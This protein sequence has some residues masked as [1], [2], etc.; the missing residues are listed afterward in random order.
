MA[1][2]TTTA[3]TKKD[4]APVAETVSTEATNSVKVEEASSEKLHSNEQNATSIPDETQQTFEF[5]FWELGELK[6]KVQGVEVGHDGAPVDMFVFDEA[7]FEAF[8][9]GQQHQYIG[10]F[11]ITS[12][13][14]LFQIP[15]D[16]TWYLAVRPVKADDHY[17]VAYRLMNFN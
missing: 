16:G 5:R 15:F 13:R 12:A 6:G 4:T 9:T 11:G 10:G 14:H 7:N 2:R 8:K 3:R 1:K 17:E